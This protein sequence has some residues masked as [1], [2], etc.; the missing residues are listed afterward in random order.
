LA[1]EWIEQWCCADLLDLETDGIELTEER[2]REKWLINTVN[3]SIPIGHEDGRQ[4]SPKRNTMNGRNPK[5]CR[6]SF[7]CRV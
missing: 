4:S 7:T 3:N 5:I 1:I 6:E 2:V